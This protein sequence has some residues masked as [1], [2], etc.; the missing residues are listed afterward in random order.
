MKQLSIETMT[1]VMEKFFTL[2]ASIRAGE[3][4]K[5]QI[6][7]SRTSLRNHSIPV[8]SRQDIRQR[9]GQAF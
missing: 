8:E 5:V 4:G 2:D 9:T 3:K 7:E 1:K 6:N